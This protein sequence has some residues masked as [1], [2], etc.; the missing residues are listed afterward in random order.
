GLPVFAAGGGPAYLLGPTGGYLLAFPLA[1]FVAGRWSGGSPARNLGAALAALLVI[2][3]G[4]VS[5]L[6]LQTGSAD[7]A[8][9]LGSLPF[10]ATGAVKVALAAG[11]VGL[12][13]PRLRS[14]L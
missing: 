13:R 14:A 7:A 5:W 9:R 6:A 10:L 8:L 3:A 11:L 4:G 1:A 2:H 12:L